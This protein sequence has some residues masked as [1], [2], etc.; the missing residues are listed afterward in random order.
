MH[1]CIITDNKVLGR[2]TK[3]FFKVFIAQI[4]LSR[5]FTSIK[6]T[7][8]VYKCC[9]IIIIIHANPF[10][11]ILELKNSNGCQHGKVSKFYKIFLWKQVCTYP[12]NWWLVQWSTSYQMLTYPIGGLSVV[13]SDYW[14]ELMYL[15]VD[16]LWHRA[17]NGGE[18]QP[19]GDFEWHSNQQHFLKL[20]LPLT[21]LQP[22][23]HLPSPQSVKQKEL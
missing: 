3:I 5:E 4:E 10:E 19:F 7:R 16:I 14:S 1:E 6:T 22:F 20:G 17:I 9:S 11:K 12:I 15:V 21:T 13:W 23:P 8:Y 2:Q 18:L